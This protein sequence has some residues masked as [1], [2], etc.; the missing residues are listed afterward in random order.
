MKKAAM[1]V[2]ISTNDQHT[3]LSGNRIDGV[4]R[5]PRLGRTVRR[6]QC[7]AVRTVNGGMIPAAVSH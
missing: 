5:E 4:C 1:Y 6:E 2:R 3:G 7:K